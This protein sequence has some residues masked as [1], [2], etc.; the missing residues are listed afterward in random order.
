MRTPRY[1]FASDNTAGICPEAWA[2]LVEANSGSASSYG[3][4]EWTQ[5]VCD[6]VRETFATDC[7]VYLIF[8]GTAAN[9][10]ALAQLGRSYHSVIC[11]E[12]AHIDNDECGACEFYSGGSKLLPAG[13]P[14][15]K[16]DLAKIE[17][18]LARQNELHSP[19]PR[20][21]SLT[22]ATEMGTVYSLSEVH[23]I[24]HFARERG[25]F[26]HMDG[27]RL[28][29]AVASLGIGLAEVTSQAGVDVLSWGG[30][31][32]GLA[33]GELVI[34]FD[35]RLSRDFE[36][37]AKQAGQLASKMRFLAAPWLGLL[38]DGVWLRNAQ[39]ANEAAHRLAAGLKRAG[40]ELCFPVESSAIFLR[41]N[42]ATVSG[43]NEKGWQFFKFIE[44][45]VYRL[46]CSWMTT[47]EAIAA[48]IADFEAARSCTASTAA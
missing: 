7:D 38:E 17:N 1:D 39:W 34:F 36:Y 31:K 5:R 30:T 35:R 11:H 9:A 47:E 22:Q 28:A 4:D 27:A 8:N 48:I 13:G 10:L 14:Q 45:D 29:N 40:A 25:L 37:R 26:L 2:K 19:K 21:I 15:G 46:M 24:S 44:P 32:N 12:R 20:T 23:A 41:L 6:K 43:M 18:V 42:G 33:G 16:L 3:E